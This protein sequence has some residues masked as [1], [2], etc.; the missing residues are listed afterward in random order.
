LGI[1][2]ISI[3]GSH[4]TSGS[5]RVNDTYFNT[6][7]YNTTAWRNLVMCQEVG[8][9]FG[10][11]HQDESGADLHTCMDYANSPDQDNMHPNQHD[12]EMLASIYAHLDSSTTIRATAGSSRGGLKRIDDDLWVEDLENGRK[13][14]VHVYWIDR[15]RHHHAPSEG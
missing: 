5:V 1:A 4:I 2:S 14:F 9:T 11:G 6:A 8:H 3:S 7:Q 12:Y 15:D 13:R 10:L